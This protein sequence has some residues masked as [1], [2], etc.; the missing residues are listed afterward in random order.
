MGAHA[1]LKT[2]IPFSHFA[3]EHQHPLTLI[4]ATIKANHHHQH[5]LV[6]KIIQQCGGNLQGKIIAV[7]GLT[8]KAQ[9]DDMRDSAS[10]VIIPELIRHGAT[11]HAYD[12]QGMAHAKTMLPASVHFGTSPF[13]VATDADAI[14]IIT[15]WPEFYAVDLT[16][17]RSIMKHP[18]LI[19]LRNGF[20]RQTM[21][22]G[23]FNY[24]CIGEGA[25]Q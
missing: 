5:H 23:G 1:F 20:K 8:F 25:T 24:M 21:V 3:R 6:N 12:P 16:Q 14:V 19:D 17:L 11:I 10:L 13:D 15:E 7:W 2:P 18:L 22:Q 9:T 4:E